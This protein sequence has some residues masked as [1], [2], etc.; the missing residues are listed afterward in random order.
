M[1]GMDLAYR[2]IMPIFIYG[3]LGWLWQTQGQGPLWAVPVG[4]GLGMVAGLWA[5]YKSTPK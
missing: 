2:C 3:G 4:M 1:Q 5:V